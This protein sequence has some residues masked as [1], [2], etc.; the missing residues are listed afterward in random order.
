MLS[1]VGMG[2][3]G[4]FR[5]FPDSDGHPF[6]RWLPRGRNR[7]RW[8][9]GALRCYPRSLC[10]TA[11]SLTAFLEARHGALSAL[12][13]T[14]APVVAVGGT[15]SCVKNVP[16][17]WSAGP[18]RFR[19]L[20]RH[21][22]CS[23]TPKKRPRGTTRSQCGA[24]LRIRRGASTE[25]YSIQCCCWGDICRERVTPLSVRPAFETES[26]RHGTAS[27]YSLG[28]GRR[29][30]TSRIS[31]TSWRALHSPNIKCQG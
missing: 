13:V 9:R 14:V 4:P 11:P 6:A 8:T 5:L 2:L 25:G 18:M 28:D 7:V 30:W 19:I 17:C 12:P 16:G 31:D 23:R 10:S 21:S 1:V 27:L 24:S 3:V 15:R 22:L 26:V 29:R 20:P